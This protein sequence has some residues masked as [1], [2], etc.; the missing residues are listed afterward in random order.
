[1]VRFADAPL[2]M[3]LWNDDC[4]EIADFNKIIGLESL[5]STNCEAI[6]KVDVTLVYI[7]FIENEKFPRKDAEISD[8]HETFDS[9]GWILK[10]MKL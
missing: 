7:E 10:M 9:C 4:T 8:S 5:L 3:Y 1:M 6:G 2:N